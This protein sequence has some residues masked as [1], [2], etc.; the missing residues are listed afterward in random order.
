MVVF[1]AVA[2]LHITLLR[3]PYF[4]DEAGYYIPAAHDFL[5]HGDLTPVSTPS[6]GHPPLMIIYLAVC[7]KLFG[8]APLIT[9]LAMLFIAAFGVVQLYRLAE[10]LAGGA[11]AIATTVCFGV[12]PV[13]F[14][15]SSL[16]HADLPATAL[17]LWGLRLTYKHGAARWTWTI[18]FAL[19]SLAK[20]IA[21]LVPLALAFWEIASLVIGV[22]L[23]RK[24]GEARPTLRSLAVSPAALNAVAYLLSTIPLALWFVYHRL[25]TGYWFGSP[26][27]FRYNVGATLAPLRIV[28]AFVQRVWQVLGYMNLWVLTLLTAAAMLLKP[29]Q[30]AGVMRRRIAVPVQLAFFSVII[31]HLLF[32][33][34]VGGAELARYMMPVIPL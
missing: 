26:E 22:R 7:W 4:W 25:H 3:L 30:D 18:A 14:A 9:R 16:A 15:Q 20:E 28:L 32:H 6:S 1:L 17:T 8:Y 23:A 34:V 33:S 24:I 10:E 2:L 31:V 27:F 5:L 19:A 29:L 13:F 11:V 21:I 12:Y